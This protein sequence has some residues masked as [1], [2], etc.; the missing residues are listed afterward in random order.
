MRPMAPA[1]SSPEGSII[2]PPLDPSSPVVAG[3]SAATAWPTFG[4]M[5][6]RLSRWIA[7]GL[8]AGLVPIGPGTIGT[9]VAWLLYLPGAQLFGAI[10]M[11]LVAL[12]GFVLGIWAV[13]RAGEAL[14]DVDHSAIVWDEVVAF[15]LVLCLIP[16]HWEAQLAA[17][18][19]FRVFDVWKPTPIREVEQRLHTPFGVMADDVLAAGYTLAVF[20]IWGKFR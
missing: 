14:G 19:L 20:M 12:A 15:W 1:A 10:G 17:F 11:G 7:L 5:R 6:P 3:A 18:V 16:Q 9:L 8:G 13:R 2:S 4:F